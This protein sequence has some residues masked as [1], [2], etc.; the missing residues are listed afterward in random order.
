[1]NLLHKILPYPIATS[2]ITGIIVL[3]PVVPIIAQA[4]TLNGAGATFPEPL[5]QTYVHHIKDK[6]PDLTINYQAIGSKG[7]INQVVAGTID[8]GG[9][10]AAMQDSKIAE[11]RNGIIL[12]PT[13]GG[14]VSVVYH[15]PGIDKL[16]ISRAVLPAIFSG[17]I[18]HWNDPK[19][20]S[21][22][23]GVKLP[24][25]PIKCVVRADGSG[26]T[27]IFTN[28]LS[29]TSVYFKRKIGSSTAPRWNLSNLLKGK[30]NPGVAALVARTPG[31][32]GYVEYDYAVQNKLTSALI[33]NRKGKFVAPSL[34]TAQ[35]ALSHVR[36]PANFRV[37]IG[38]PAQGYPIV[39]FTWMVIY[40]HYSHRDKADAIKKLINWVLTDGQQY[41]ANFNYTKI[42]KD[43][44]NRVLQTVNTTVKP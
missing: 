34:S 13:A 37:F 43:V 7:G 40:K 10:D 31:S 35:E 6:Y 1:M 44:V 17:R 29:A 21:D 41:N 25:Q 23:P 15:L 20:Q 26:T 39:G 18:T 38:D 42:P 9:S 27:L 11:V 32:L 5:Y 28:H 2:V 16:K 12:I 24:N 36:F 8:F 3:S 14:A 30:G 19:I 4:E 22:N 33:E